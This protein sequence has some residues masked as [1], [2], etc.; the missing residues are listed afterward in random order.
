MPLSRERKEAVLDSY[1]LRV[2][3]IA[4]RRKG[5]SVRSFKRFTSWSPQTVS[6]VSH[7][8]FDGELNRSGCSYNNRSSSLIAHVRECMRRI[9][10]Y[11]PRS[12]VDP[13]SKVIRISY[14]N[15]ALGQYLTR[16]SRELL[17]TIDVMSTDS[18]KEFLKAFFNDEGC[19]DFRP[20]RNVRQIRG[21][22][23]NVAVLQIVKGLLL[24]MGIE[25][26][27]KKPN[28]VVIVGRENLLRFGEK[29]N[30]SPGVRING[31]RSN[32]LWKQPMEKR[33][34]LERAIASYKPAG[35]SGVHR[36]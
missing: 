35:S 16:K 11:D 23:K 1:R 4:A 19:M 9:Y 13:K 36:R 17:G 22:Q 21:Y 29:V 15:V 20:E 30:F 14:Y 8:I 7:L 10:D 27:V 26:T 31:L 34:L 6:L 25:S 32:S 3:K 18:K 12:Y 28:E 2:R 33:E 5:K 24:D